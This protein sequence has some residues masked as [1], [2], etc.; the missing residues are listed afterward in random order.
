MS[1]SSD[2][3]SSAGTG[4]SR[5]TRATRVCAGGNFHTRSTTR[6]NNPMRSP[7][8]GRRPCRSTL[9][10]PFSTAERARIVARSRD[11]ASSA[12]L[13][14]KLAADPN[15]IEW[16]QSLGRSPSRLPVAV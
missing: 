14:P 9:Q 6:P 10:P 8:A 16:I 3:P 4:T 11:P 2:A 15:D 5:S 1:V 7:S 13:A 12:S